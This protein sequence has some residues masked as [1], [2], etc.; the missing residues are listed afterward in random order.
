MFL[1]CNC[2]AGAV[3]GEGAS[4]ILLSV[5]SHFIGSHA[6]IGSMMNSHWRRYSRNLSGSW[7]LVLHIIFNRIITQLIRVEMLEWGVAWEIAALIHSL[8]T[9]CMS[10][11]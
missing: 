9:F 7:I 4:T 2:A 1:A 3:V 5:W 8:S 11:D 10:I 6:W